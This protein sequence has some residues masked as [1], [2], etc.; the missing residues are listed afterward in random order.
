MQDVRGEHKSPGEYRTSQNWIGG[1][2]PSNAMYIPP[3][4]S[5]IGNELSD[6]EKFINNEK[7]NMP[8]LIKITMI[9]Y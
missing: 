4:P 1:S 9:H 2:K 7:I 8:E 5:V 3:I 6:L